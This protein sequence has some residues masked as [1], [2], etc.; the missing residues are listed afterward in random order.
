MQDQFDL[1][2]NPAR[3]IFGAGSMARTAEMVT[4]LGC[5]R[6]LVLAT[7][8]QAG[9]AEELAASI[10]DLAAGTYTNATMH[11]PVDVTEDC[12]GAFRDQ[13]ADCTIAIGGGSTTGLGKAVAWRIGQPQIVIPTTYAGSEV[14]PVLGETTAGKKTTFSDPKILPDAVIYDPETTYG[15]PLGLSVTSALNAVAHAAEGLYA[16]NRNPISTLMALEGAS[17]VLAALPKV[18]DDP[19]NKDARAT[20]LYGAWLCGAVLGAVGMALH[21]KLCHTL[22]GTFNLPHAETHS[23]VLPHS[24]A[25]N[26]AAVPDLLAPVAAAT[27]SADAGGGLYRLASS[28][29]APTTLQELGMPEDGIDRAAELAVSNPYWNPRPFEREQIR[30][31]IENAYFGRPPEPIS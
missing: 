28:L 2:I 5:E 19:Q 26:E 1:T 12:V 27:G 16:Q 29:A 11:T 20:L 3:I 24:I 18:V 4:A 7:P 21:H 8:A 15:L 13:R 25:F 31:L 14:T 22:G 6:A 23:V 30:Q 9:M 17:S 10:G